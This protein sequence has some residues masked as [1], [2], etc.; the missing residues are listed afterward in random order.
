MMYSC[1]SH[2][3]CAKS[4]STSEMVRFRGRKKKEKVGDPNALMNH[5]PDGKRCIGDSGMRGEPSKISTTKP[6][7]SKEVKKFFSRVRARQETL[8][9]RMKN[10]DVLKNRFRHGI[11]LHK[12]CLEAVAVIVQYGET[13]ERYHVCFFMLAEL[14]SVILFNQKWKTDTPSLTLNMIV[15]LHI[16]P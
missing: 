6:G 14:N 9:T 7:H 2:V 1:L 16:I 10:F 12:M 15:V 5:I 13:V 4:A 3:T 11:N 8:F